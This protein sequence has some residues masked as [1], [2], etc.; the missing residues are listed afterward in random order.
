MELTVRQRTPAIR[1][2][3]Q[4]SIFQFQ[5]A[6]RTSRQAHEQPC[7]RAQ[8]RGDRIGVTRALHSAEGTNMRACVSLNI[9]SRGFHL[10]QPLGAAAGVSNLAL[11]RPRTPLPIPKVTGR[12]EHGWIA[13]VSPS[14]P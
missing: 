5:N 14:S 3:R 1:V 8:R 13:P 10:A 9:M 7:C 2:K 6:G 12:G 11:Q 4:V